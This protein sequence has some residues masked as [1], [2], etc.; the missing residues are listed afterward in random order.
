M[1][2][3]R[4][5]L[6]SGAGGADRPV[7]WAHTSDLPSPWQWLTGGELLL[8]NGMS[9]P[10]QP[11]AQGELISKLV[12]VGASGLA[13]GEQMYCPPLTAQLTQTSNRLRL[14]VLWVAYPMPFI[15]ISRAVAEATLLEQ[16]QRLIRTERIYNAI[17]R[18]TDV[19]PGRSMLTAA[20][21][22]ELSCQVH[23]C[24]RETAE[25]WYP[26]DSPMDP[27]V[28]AAVRDLLRPSR[29]VRAGAF[30][31]PLADGR[32][33]RIV[34]VPTHERA[35]MVV[36]SD[37]TGS[38]DAILMQHAA[39]V[40]A[41]EMSQSLMTLEHARRAGA[42]LLAQLI[43]G[44][45]DQRSARRQ[46]LA[47]G[48]DPTHAV[49]VCATTTDP[50]RVH[51]LHVALWQRNIP[52]IAVH[53]SG[54]V[55]L[56]LHDGPSVE[57][58]LQQALG[59]G[60]RIGLSARVKSAHRVPDALREALWALRIAAREAIPV[61]RYGG[62]TPWSGIASVEEAQAL[63]D[64]TIRSL[65]DHE[66]DGLLLQTLQA[67]FDNRRSWQRTADALHLHRQTVLYRIRKI[68]EITGRDLSTTNDIAEL[69][70]GLQAAHLLQAPGA[71]GRP[72]TAETDTVVP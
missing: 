26:H 67:F 25:P 37:G 13:I 9:F 23:V 33:V 71:H 52:H 3:L 31:I 63:I 72:T 30:A 45:I 29:T 66:H 38:L 46:L 53:R 15:A 21:S 22:Q 54:L 16:S 1:P 49:L 18:A 42:E 35:L 69:W 27:P 24:H 4:L 62:A 11:R 32:E 59:E 34:E 65:L 58:N 64:R 17:N 44:H 28:A 43:D 19:E 55:Q 5:R 41:L 14:P 47:E 61:A 51:E 50:S 48:L 57:T 56:L 40:V 6:H 70:L 36:V 68:E 12:G 10:A 39:T 20:L 60:G 2:H 8:T 7:S